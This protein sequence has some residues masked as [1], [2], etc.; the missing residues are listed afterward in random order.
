MATL[1]ETNKKMYVGNVFQIRH[2]EMDHYYRP[3]TVLCDRSKKF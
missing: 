3:N 1:K 2:N